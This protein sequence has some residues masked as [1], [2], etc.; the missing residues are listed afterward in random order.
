MTINVYVSSGFRG[1]PRY[2][3]LAPNTPISLLPRT[4]SWK[5]VRS[6]EARELG[7]SDT[8]MADL[9][10][11]GFGTRDTAGDAD[12][13]VSGPRAC[14]RTRVRTVRQPMGETRNGHLHAS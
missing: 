6:A 2:A 5:Y 14:A 12:S 8:D 7:L 9:L 3:Y 10:R 13:L 4:E 11:A 1:S